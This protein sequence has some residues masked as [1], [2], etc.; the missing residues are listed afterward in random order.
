M[1]LRTWLFSS[2]LIG[3]SMA[4]LQILAMITKICCFYKK[5]FSEVI[6]VLNIIF[7]VFKFLGYNVVGLVVNSNIDP[8][9]LE[10]CDDSL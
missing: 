6:S 4:G 1:S 3:I 9:D 7:F 8:N 10:S 2:A 5:K